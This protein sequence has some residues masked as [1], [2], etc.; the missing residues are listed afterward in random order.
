MSVT[1]EPSV[2]AEREGGV[3]TLWLNRPERMNAWTQDMED[4]YYD[5]LADA[6]ADPDVRVVV[7]TGAGR[8]F[9]AGA[10]MEILDSLASHAEQYRP[11]RRPKIFPL[12][13]RKPV[14]A[15]IN[16]ACAGLG[17][18]QALYCDVRFVASDAKLTTAFARRGLVAE[19]GLSWLLPRLVGPE[20]ALDLLLSARVV[21]GEEAVALGLASRAVERDAVLAAARTYAADLAANCSPRSMAVMK[22]QILRHL[23][24]DLPTALRESDEVMEAA[25]DWPDVQEGVAS[26]LERRAPAFPPLDARS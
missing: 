1:S 7:V 6:D 4:R 8:A 3:L 22:Q 5:A 12:T 14:I 18:I 9:C 19:H 24:A 2:L 20:R 17:L 25:F 13:I 15:A 26:F 10:D 21:R 11:G 16:G 23:D